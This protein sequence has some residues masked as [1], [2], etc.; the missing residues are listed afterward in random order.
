MVPATAGDWLY[1]R[2]LELIVYSSVW[3]AGG[4]FALTVFSSRVLGLGWSIQP[5]LLVLFSCLFIYNLDHVIDTRV[6]RVPDRRAQEYFTRPAVLVLLVVSA[7]L[8]GLMVGE[9]PL[10]AKI[11]F[12]GYTVTGL[13]YGLPLLPGRGG[14]WLRLKD[15]PLTK[16]WLVGLTV[17]GGVVCLPAAWAGRW[18]WPE[19]GT[20]GLFM[21]VFVV[22]NVHMFDVRDLASDREHRVATL[23]VVLGVRRAKLA[24]IALNLVML[25]AVAWGWGGGLIRSHPEVILATA[26][27]VVYVLLVR[28][29]TPRT[30]FGIFVDGC[31]YLPLMLLVLR[32]ALL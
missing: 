10:Q 27:T 1:Q 14:R 30:H 29:T 32:D 17:A 22:S 7:L 5:A 20:L 15:I 19:M 8:T 2:F 9:A 13:L 24:V 6:Q 16:A 4:L 12:A 11:V 26:A 23:P 28:V 31:L 25:A 18:P 21:G 3:A